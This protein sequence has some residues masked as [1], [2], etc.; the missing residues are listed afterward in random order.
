[1]SIR[2]KDFYDL[3]ARTNVEEIIYPERYVEIDFNDVKYLLSDM[4]NFSINESYVTYEQDDL[5]LSLTYECDYILVNPGREGEKLFID[6]ASSHSK[7]Q[8]VR[9][10]IDEDGKIEIQV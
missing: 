6:V 3:K 2:W 4:D 8:Q 5:K 1:M 9:V 10:Y 7:C